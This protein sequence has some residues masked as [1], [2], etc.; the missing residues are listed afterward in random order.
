[1]GE[2]REIRPALDLPDGVTSLPGWA[3]RLHYD[4][5]RA[6]SAPGAVLVPASVRALVLELSALVGVLAR[7]VE[8]LRAAGQ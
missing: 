6:L 4:T 3:M 1:M 2:V 5:G 7:E 8:R